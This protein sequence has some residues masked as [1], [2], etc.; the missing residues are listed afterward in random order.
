MTIVI[1]G[2]RNYTDYPKA[3]IFI[4]QCLENFSPCNKI[5]ILSGG[6]RGADALG[7]RYATEHG[8]PVIRF[9]PNWQRYGKRAGP[10]RNRAMVD[11]CD[12][13]ICFWDG[14][15]HGTH[16]LISYTNQQQKPLFIQ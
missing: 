8:L 1:A 5:I 12:A 10:I 15:S 7:E 3:E 2:C 9:L 11:A 14:N 4:S 16:S 13:V 6:C